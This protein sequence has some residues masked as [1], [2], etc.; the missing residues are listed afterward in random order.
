M[1]AVEI[2]IIARHLGMNEGDFIEQHTRLRQDRTGLALTDKPNGECHFLD[3]DDCSI[4]AVK[5][6][7]CRDF[8]NLWTRPEARQYCQAIPREV[9]EEEYARLMR[10]ATGREIDPEK[11]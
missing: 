11:R 5:P 9:S 2:S 1:T 3:G 8:P 6:Q 4:Q 7:Q 10:G